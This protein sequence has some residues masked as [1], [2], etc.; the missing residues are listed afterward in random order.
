MDRYYHHHHH[1]VD[2]M[3][4]IEEEE[5]AYIER[6]E[7]ENVSLTEDVISPLSTAKH[8]QEVASPRP[9]TLQSL[10][11][12]SLEDSSITDL[13]RKQSLEEKL[14]SSSENSSISSIR[15]FLYS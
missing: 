11:S 13:R 1:V 5:E 14:R 6:I 15:F 3:E 12:S 2:K 7:V 4:S 10:S 8:E 9:P